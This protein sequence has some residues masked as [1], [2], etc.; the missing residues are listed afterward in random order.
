MIYFYFL[1]SIFL[2]WFSVNT[3]N[4]EEVQVQAAVGSGGSG[5]DSPS[6]R[7]GKKFQDSLNGKKDNRRKTKTFEPYKK[8]DHFEVYT[9]KKGGQKIKIDKKDIDLFNKWSTTDVGTPNPDEGGMEP[10]K[11]KVYKD[12]GKFLSARQLNEIRQEVGS[13]MATVEGLKDGEEKDTTQQDAD[14]P[15]DECT[16]NKGNETIDKKKHKEIFKDKI[17][18]GKCEDAQECANMGQKTQF[19]P[20][21]SDHNPPWAKES[22]QTFNEEVHKPS[23]KPGQRPPSSV[24]ND[25]RFNGKSKQKNQE[26]SEHENF[27]EGK[28]K[29][30]K[31]SGG[32]TMNA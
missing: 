13:K 7:I 8:K 20:A 10:E 24:V 22:S 17:N 15:G 25:A 31:D 23:Q 19:G 1:F 18:D 21:Q 12:L 6:G 14:K 27:Q 5:E 4:L 3:E 29:K 28:K 26:E 16:D 11:L 2:S 30:C 32:K 9:L